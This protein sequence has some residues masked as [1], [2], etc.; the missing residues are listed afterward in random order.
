MEI[1]VGLFLVLFFLAFCCEFVD[2]SLGMGYGTI[3]TPTLL[4][5]GFE[6]LMVIPAVLL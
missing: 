4:I 1:T 2:S 6:P 3:L 5:M